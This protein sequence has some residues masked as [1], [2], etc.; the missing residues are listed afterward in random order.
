MDDA[1]WCRFCDTWHTPCNNHVC[2]LEAL[3]Q[4]VVALENRAAAAEATLDWLRVQAV[5]DL[6]PG[7][8]GIPQV[9]WDAVLGANK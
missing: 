9:E 1:Q 3:R 2:E 5:A 8:V 4:H 7:F 6:S